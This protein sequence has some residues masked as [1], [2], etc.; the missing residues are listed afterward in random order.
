MRRAAPRKARSVALEMP[1][2]A[3]Q[4]PLRRRSDS[5]M[6]VKDRL[7]Q[8]CLRVCA[9]TSTVYF[10]S[11][12]LVTVDPFEGPFSGSILR[13]IVVGSSSIGARSSV[14]NGR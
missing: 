12:R 6:L 14:G 4:F 8:I 11:G 13:I 7:Q 2:H 9:G 5:G 10:R 1:T 3:T